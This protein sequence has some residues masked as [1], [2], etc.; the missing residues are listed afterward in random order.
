M[1]AKKHS[2]IIDDII[3]QLKP[4]FDL[5][6]QSVYAYLDDANKLCNKNFAA[7]LGYTSAD[8]WASVEGNFPT[9]FVADNSQ[10]TLISSFQN[11]ME[12]GVGSKI[13][14]DWKKK[15]GGTVKTN[16]IIVPVSVSGHL[17]ALHFITK[18]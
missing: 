8:E 16:V 4:V 18:T 10:K 2:E 6:E 1:A 14:V 3:E 12:K 15:S 5:S 9:L 13:Q 17:F 7:L 11:A